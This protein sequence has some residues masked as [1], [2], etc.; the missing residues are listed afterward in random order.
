MR[1]ALCFCLLLSHALAADLAVEGWHHRVWTVYPVEKIKADEEPPLTSKAATLELSAARGGHEPFVLLLRPEVPLREVSAV[2]EDLK[3][4]GGAVIP[5]SNITAQR[6]GYVFVDEPSGTRIQQPM[7]YP[8]GIGQ[9]PDPL[10]E[11]KGDVRPMHNL[12]F[13]VTIHVRR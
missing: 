12:L 10:L 11:N 8:S 7:P 9:Y 4:A 3:S 13:L 1:L 2:M 6:L 5:A